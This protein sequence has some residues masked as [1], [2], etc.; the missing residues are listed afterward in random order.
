MYIDLNETYK[1]TFKTDF[2]SMNGIYKVVQKMTYDEVILAGID[3]VEKLYSRVDKDAVAWDE[4]IKTYREL[5]FYKLEEPG[6]NV[7]VKY[8][9]MPEALIDGYPDPNIH[10]YAKLT[11][12]TDLG[13]H[14]D[15]AVVSDIIAAVKDL[16]TT[17]YGIDN[18]PKL[19]TYK[20]S[21]LTDQEY[22]AI[23]AG[24]EAT[25]TGAVNYRAESLRLAQELANA[26]TKI[27]AL[28]Q[29]IANP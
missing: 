25:K 22:A 24:R 17:A 23:V 10:E 18:D 2:Q 20:Q 29:I 14:T 7:D 13:E 5:P 27:Q 4:D 8:L 16:L 11:L 19:V 12:V 6:V 3:M 26:Q 1:F 21:W 28:E 15:D 9:Y